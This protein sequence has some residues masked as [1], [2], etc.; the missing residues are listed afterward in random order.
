MIMDN[1]IH[2]IVWV[3]RDVKQSV[4]Q[5]LH[6]FQIGVTQIAKKMGE[7]PRPVVGER[8]DAHHDE[9]DTFLSMYKNKHVTAEAGDER[10]MVVFCC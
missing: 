9:R 1:H 8:E 3:R 2:F 7:W 5:A 10:M 6:G 4:L